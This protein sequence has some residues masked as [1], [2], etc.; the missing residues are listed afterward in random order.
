MEFS[1]TESFFFLSLSERR[2]V[3]YN[4]LATIQVQ[5]IERTVLS[6]T[7]SF[8]FLSKIKYGATLTG[9]L[10]SITVSQELQKLQFQ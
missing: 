10:H 8:S 5:S 7:A 9:L 4:P 1:F 3:S 6:I 2:F